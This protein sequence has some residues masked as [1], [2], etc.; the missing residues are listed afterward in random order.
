MGLAFL[1]VGTVALFGPATWG[2]WCLAA[3]FG[4]LHIAFGTVIARR[5]GG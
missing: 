4:G 1:A 2:D 5:Y 3:G